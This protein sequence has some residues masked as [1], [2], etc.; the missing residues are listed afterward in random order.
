MD[1][2]DEVADMGI[3]GGKQQ[4]VFGRDECEAICLS[5]ATDECYGFDI[6]SDDSCW[7][8]EKDTEPT[9]RTDGTKHYRRRSC[10]KWGLHTCIYIY[11]IIC[12]THFV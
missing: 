10:G 7:L 8:A 5:K 12:F 2:F 9:D 11:Y 1:G 6:G 4:Q 3:N